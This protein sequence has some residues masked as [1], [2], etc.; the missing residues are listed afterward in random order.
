MKELKVLKPFPYGGKMR[1]KN[2]RIMASNKHAAVL[3]LTGKAKELPKERK[4]K[5]YKTAVMTPEPEGSGRAAPRS[6]RQQRRAE[7]RAQQKPGYQ[8]SDMAAES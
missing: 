4:A 7:R 5:E 1:N 3:S 2:E 6:N 8:R